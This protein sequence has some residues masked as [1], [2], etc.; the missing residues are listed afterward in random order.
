[1]LSGLAGQ[2]LV[3]ARIDLAV[4]LEVGDQPFPKLVDSGTIEE[5]ARGDTHESFLPYGVFG[6]ALKRAGIA[7]EFARQ[8][9]ECRRGEPRSCD[10]F[11]KT[12]LEF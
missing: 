12:P 10:A 4:G 1:M 3:P 8:R 2:L 7:L 11:Q 5:E 6:Q 9:A